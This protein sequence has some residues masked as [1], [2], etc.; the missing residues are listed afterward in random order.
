M[1]SFSM[2]LSVAALLLG[3]CLHPVMAW[4]KE[5]FAYKEKCQP[6]ALT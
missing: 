4:D 1:R 5:T 6:R 2:L 3:L